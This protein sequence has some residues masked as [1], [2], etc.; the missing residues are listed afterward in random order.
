MEEKN[1]PKRRA[2]SEVKVSNYVGRRLT[3]S[4]NIISKYT[5]IKEER[6]YIKDL[7]ERIDKGEFD[8]DDIVPQQEAERKRLIVY[9]EEMDIL[10][11]HKEKQGFA[12][13][14]EYLTRV[15]V[16]DNKALNEKGGEVFEEDDEE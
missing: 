5:G 3:N 15:I 1:T 12:T 13:V 11:E 9:K 10:K 2:R 7:I 4:V 6:A 16:A 14:Q 8:R